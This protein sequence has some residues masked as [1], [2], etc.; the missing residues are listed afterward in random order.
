MVGAEAMVRLLDV[1]GWLGRQGSRLLVVAL[2][3]GLLVPVL[4]EAAKSAM[5]ASVLL[6]TFGAF[7]RID[8][9]R[10]RAEL[11]HRGNLPVQGWVMLGVP[12]LAAGAV[13]VL[14]PLPELG[15]AIILA[16]LA[17]PVGSAAAIAMMLGLDATL[18]LV[19]SVS[20]GLAS[21]VVAPL[22]GPQLGGAGI[23]LD[24]GVLALRL[25][26]LVGGG[27]ALAV[28]VRRG[29]G[30]RLP[31]VQGAAVG[32]CVI[33]LIGLAL[34]AMQKMGARLEEDAGH[35][36]AMLGL[37]LAVNIGLQ[38]TGLLLFTGGGVRRAM[39]IGL[40]SGNRNVA[41]MWAAALPIVEGRPL[42]ELYL[43]TSVTAIFVLPLLIQEGGR[44][45][46]WL[47]A[48]RAALG[49]A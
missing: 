15:L 10:I 21:P 31:D 35:V 36:A 20:A 3:A 9:Q 11:T 1:L 22:L 37:A 29:A 47:R 4:A 30:R 44:L 7:L 16:T 32:I 38:L 2:G 34:G 12:L 8:P 43:A 5:A 6:V 27:A 13:A 45:L 23:V 19:C 25:L 39:T 41:L 46:R 24:P 40:L 48:G 33:G 28:L 26:L 17:P 18:A 42:A 14:E 49:R